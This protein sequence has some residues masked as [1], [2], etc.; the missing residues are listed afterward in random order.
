MVE[1]TYATTSI[2]SYLPSLDVDEQLILSQPDIRLEFMLSHIAFRSPLQDHAVH[3][4]IKAIPQLPVMPC[5]YGGCT[6]FGRLAKLQRIHDV[7]ATTTAPIR[8]ALLRRGW[9]P[10]STDEFVACGL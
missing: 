7:S 3:A 8:A 9:E 6:L 5:E 2:A 4:I 10:T 1:G